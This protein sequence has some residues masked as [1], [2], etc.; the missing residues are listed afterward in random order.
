MLESTV[1]NGKKTT[2]G[3][4]GPSEVVPGVSVGGRKD[5]DR[6]EGSR[7]CVLDEA[8]D[9]VPAS[10]HIP[11]YDEQNDRA[12]PANLDR[13][14]RAIT[15]ERAKGRPVLVFCGHGVRRGPL[16]AAWYLHRSEG[17]TLAEAYA[18]IRAVRPKIEEARE[19]IGDIENLEGA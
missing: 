4:G 11:I 7:F 13:L 16:A 10:T 12:L 1:G 5:A 14:A 3:G 17:L 19:W 2:R 18:R 8:P 9:D 6:F 15:E